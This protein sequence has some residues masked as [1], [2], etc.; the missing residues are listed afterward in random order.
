MP[1]TPHIGAPGLP[2]IAETNTE[3]RAAADDADLA[4]ETAELAH[5][6]GSA[7]D[8]RPAAAFRTTRAGR[9]KVELR[10][11]AAPQRRFRER[12]RQATVGG[13][14]CQ[15]SIGDARTGIRSAPPRR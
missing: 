2:K 9:R 7:G 3:D 15:E 10:T 11:D 13:I 1:S 6:L 12:D 5:V 14:V 8:H 4:E